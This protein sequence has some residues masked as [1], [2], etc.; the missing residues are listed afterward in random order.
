MSDQLTHG[1]FL[2]QLDSRFRLDLEGTNAIELELTEVSEL[3][4]ARRQEIFSIVFRGP[5]TVVL[6]QRMYRLEHDE[7]G[8][9]DLLL[10]PIKKDN[11]GVYYEAVFNRLLEFNVNDGQGQ[12]PS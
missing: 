4:S 7:M 10:V 9:L 8:S 6:P 12:R 5:L 11:E 2:E 1:A 3:T